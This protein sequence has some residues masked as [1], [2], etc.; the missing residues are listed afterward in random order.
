MI[1]GNKVYPIATVLALTI[2][3]GLGF[4][5]SFI[6]DFTT[7]A[8]SIWVAILIFTIGVVVNANNYNG[9]SYDF[10]GAHD[11]AGIGQFRAYDTSKSIGDRNKHIFGEEE[12]V[13]D[14]GSIGLYGGMFSFLFCLIV[15]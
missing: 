1:R 10:G 6:L 7:R 4:I 2:S 8:L 12:L 3:L 15:L 11:N 13:L 14:L 5:F 9:S